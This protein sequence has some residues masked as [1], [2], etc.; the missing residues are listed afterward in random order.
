[1]ERRGEVVAAGGGHDT[2]SEKPIANADR[3]VLIVMSI[4]FSLVFVSV[5]LV[6]SAA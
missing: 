4:S 3:G 2:A 6:D 5:N 1:M